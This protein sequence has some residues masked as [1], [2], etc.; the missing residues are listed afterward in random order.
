MINMLFNPIQM[1]SS[2][3]DF[4]GVYTEFKPAENLRK[5]IYCYWIS[6]LL[7]E[8]SIEKAEMQ[9][10]ELVIP[11]GCID[12]IFG[13]DKSGKSCRNILVGT[14]SKRANVKMEYDNIQTFG[15]RFYPGGLQAFIKES[16]NE[17]TNKMELIDNIGQDIFIEFEKELHNIIG[18]RNKIKFSNQYFTLTMKDKILWEDKFQNIFYHIN[19]SKGIILV[20]DIARHEVISEKQVTRIIYNRVG[21]ST[22]TFIKIIRFQNVL[23]IINLKKPAKIVEVALKAGYY[24]QAHF[25]HDFHSFSGINP[26]E[27]LNQIK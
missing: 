16:A 25:I 12:M 24:D 7:S 3:A 4:Y 5:Y 22:K 10:E 15:I 1:Q 27:Y 8:T 11:D 20:K 23:N 21:L 14:M 6:P 26:S 18:I 9:S 17:F 2:I 13:T 19:K